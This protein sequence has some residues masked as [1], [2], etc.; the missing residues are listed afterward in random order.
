MEEIH[1]KFCTVILSKTCELKL[2]AKEK[3]VLV[4][5]FV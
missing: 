4:V 5:L 2:A 1:T 3:K